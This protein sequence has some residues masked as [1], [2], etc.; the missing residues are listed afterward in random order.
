ME[1]LDPNNTNKIDE[2]SFIG[3]IF[4]NYEREELDFYL[5]YNLIPDDLLNELKMQPS[6]SGS[7]L[8]MRNTNVTFKK[9]LN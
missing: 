8:N 1:Q 5:K 9:Y 6:Q 7:Q 4:A 2:K 3:N